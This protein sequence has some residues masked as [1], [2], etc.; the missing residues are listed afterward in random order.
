VDGPKKRVNGDHDPLGGRCPMT[1]WKPGDVIVDRA[2]L[3][4]EPSFDSGTYDV[5]IRFYSGVDPNWRNLVLSDAPPTL[6]DEHGRFK[7][8]SVDVEK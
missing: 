1:T 7:L 3:R 4:V 6:R 8:T 2:S 5:W